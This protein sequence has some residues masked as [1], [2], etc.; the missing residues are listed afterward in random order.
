MKKS[1]PSH[2]P[3]SKALAQ[4]PEKLK[5]A[6]ALHRAG[7]LLQARAVYKEILA[8]RPR[9][10][11]ALHL[12]GMIAAQTGDPEKA[13]ELIGIAIEIDPANPAPHNNR[14]LALTA[15]KQWEAAVNAFDHAI[16]LKADYAEAFFNRGNVFYHLAQWD[17]ALANYEQ[18]IALRANYVEACCNRGLVL[19]QLKRFDA[20]LASY[21]QA[22]ASKPDH[23]EAYS[24]RGIVFGELKQ[25]QA[26]LASFDQAIALKAG[27]AEAHC[28]RAVVLE[29]LKQWEAALE[30]YDQAIKLKADYAEAHRGRGH[31]LAELKQWQEAMVSYEQAL[32][33]KPDHQWLYGIWLHAKMHACDWDSLDAQI[34]RLVAR[35]ERAERAT[36]PLI[37]LGLVD[38]PEVQR[39][40]AE[41]WVEAT[42][43]ASPLPPSDRRSRSDKIRIGYFSPDFYDH[44]VARLTAE[45]FETHDRSRFEVTAFSL[46]PGSEDNMSKRLKNAFDFF[47]DVHAESDEEIARLAQQ[48]GMDIAVD[49]AGHTKGSRPRI[50]ALRAAPLQFSYIGYLGTLAAQYMDYLLADVT[51][52]PDAAQRNY[53]EKIIYLPSY[54]VND[55]QRR[56]SDRIF[57]RAELGL[58]QNGFVYC[59]F[60]A[61]YK[62]APAT[63]SVWMRILSRVEGSV[64]FLIAENQR[65]ADNLRREA[66]SRGV[67]DARLVFGKRVPTDEYLARY[68]AA[69]LFLDTLP[70]NAGTTA[71][72]ALWAG[73]PV[74]TCVGQAFAGRVAASLLT[75]I[76]LPELITS[77]SQQYEDLAVELALGPNRLADIKRRLVQNRL[78]TRLF[79]TPRFTKSLEA[80]YRIVFERFQ[81]G[82]PTEHT[83]I[84]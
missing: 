57:T 59:C 27:Y 10:F 21:G 49:L 8:V 69:D 80:A 29:E 45:L 24:N 54:Q 42:C 9:H 72:D 48:R 23:A 7:Q 13:V 34:E 51:L 35:I 11:D 26:A 2:S 82:L 75:A 5:R 52:V 28:N 58:P 39:R 14:G 37:V 56:I 31:L 78:T 12:L 63:F 65:A 84:Q 67:D 38:S 60:N 17:A 68:R 30:G 20:A 74:L 3:R 61:S 66:D 77:T 40:A 44:P 33:L 22:I 73:L 79:D 4:L 64:L 46:A 6:L 76:E 43:P 19:A 47:L 32:K 62:I 1:R 15:L 18:A 25:W 36:A 53:S 70:Y 41:I 50:F 83:I 71:S 81:A 55:S 16:A